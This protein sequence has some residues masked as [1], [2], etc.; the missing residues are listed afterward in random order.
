MAKLKIFLA[1][2]KEIIHDL[3]E[4]TT[5]IG[6]LPENALQIDDA[7]VSSS[8]AEIFAEEDRFF[9]RDLGSTNGTFIN[10][11]KIEKA[12]LHEGDEVRFGMV[13]TRFGVSEAPVEKQPA[14]SPDLTPRESTVSRRPDN[15]VSSS[16][17]K[18]DTNGKAS[19]KAVLALAALVGFL[20]FG[21]AV[22]KILQLQ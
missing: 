13:L 18:R 16:P 17:I 10:G 12:Q 4:E 20:A 9:V 21:S 11:E 8:H 7:S 3:P 19:G 2:G 15:F 14:E 22:Y 6:R 5:T 1:S